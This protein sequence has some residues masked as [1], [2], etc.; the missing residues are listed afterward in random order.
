MNAQALAVKE[1]PPANLRAFDIRSDLLAVADLVELCFKES[2]D[3]D[4]R[5]YIHQMRKTARSGRLLSLAAAASGRMDTP[6]GGFV[7]L[8]SR[9]LV[10]NL[11]LIPVYTQ[12]ISRYL[13]ANV[14]V[15]PDFRR[16]GIARSLTQAAI[17]HAQRSRAKEIWLQVD[18]ANQPAQKLYR[19]MG[20]EQRA[21]RASWQTKPDPDL[22]SPNHA[23]I[24][25]RNQQKA[26]WQQHRRW[27]DE[28]Y[29]KL[30]RWNLPLDIKQFQPGWRGS[31]QRFIREKHGQQWAAHKEDK[32]VGVL[33]WQSSSL[34]TDRLWFASSP[35]VEA[36]ALPQLL[37]Q[38]YLN[39]RPERSFVLNYPAGRGVSLFEKTGFELV[40]SLIWMQYS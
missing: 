21:H 5:L 10:A 16:R 37:S 15:H 30:I 39:L 31:I 26:D 6:P 28:L 32:L 4:G 27:L 23:A 20:F 18:A 22:A 17:A 36:E 25:V 19:G 2:L 29:P 9:E 8:E 13:I 38:A 40:R 3:A 34:Q 24:K 1:A 14:A 11:S 7:W 33:S 12:G 35:E